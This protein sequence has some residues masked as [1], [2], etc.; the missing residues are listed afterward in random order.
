MDA[1]LPPFALGFLWV[2]TR[3]ALAEIAMLGEGG[4]HATSLRVL[5]SRVS[6]LR[7]NCYF[8]GG[9]MEAAAG[10]M[11]LGFGG[12][13]LKEQTSPAWNRCWCGHFGPILGGLSL[14]SHPWVQALEEEVGLGPTGQSFQRSWSLSLTTGITILTSPMWPDFGVLSCILT[15]YYRRISDRSS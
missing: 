1:G 15:F 8:P 10:S 6:R 2:G 12:R 14:A 5:R 11:R 4:A 9:G 3:P 13:G 7:G